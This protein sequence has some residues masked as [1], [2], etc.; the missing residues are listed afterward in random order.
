MFMA[1]LLLMGMR[2]S[3]GEFGRQDGHGS[4]AG[5]DVGGGAHGQRMGLGNAFAPEYGGYEGGCGGG[6]C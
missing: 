5:A 1:Q 3:G 6:R 4:V 2:M